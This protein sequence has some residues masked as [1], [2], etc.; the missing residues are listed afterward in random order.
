MEKLSSLKNVAEAT[1]LEARSESSK[2]SKLQV[3][4]EKPKR[5]HKKEAEARAGGVARADTVLKGELAGEISAAPA[6]AP[7]KAIVI[8]N[9]GNQ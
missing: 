3:A 6:P 1:V 8:E 9:K 2:L 4:E 7:A 5:D